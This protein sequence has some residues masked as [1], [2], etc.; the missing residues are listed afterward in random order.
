M[1][2]ELNNGYICKVFFG[3]MSGSCTEYTGTVPEGYETLEDWAT[4][5]NIQA[6]KIV[7]GNLVY[8]DAKNTELERLLDLQSKKILYDDYYG[9]AANHTIKLSEKISEQQNGVVLVWS[10]FANGQPQNYNFNQFFIP[11]QFIT[12]AA[13]SGTSMIM[14]GPA[15]GV[16]GC[17]YVYI[18][19]NQITGHANNTTSGTANGITYDNSKFVLRYVFGV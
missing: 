4:N 13:G 2:Y 19:D 7:D 8:D 14:S 10:G 12:K 18:S 5:A 15:F 6:Y 11:K 17:K 16:M 3:C 9:M 1:R